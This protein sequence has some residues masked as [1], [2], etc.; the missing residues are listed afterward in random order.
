MRMRSHSH[1]QINHEKHCDEGFD[2][3]YQKVGKILFL[4]QIEVQKTSDDYDFRKE[5]NRWISCIFWVRCR[6]K[7]QAGQ[8]QRSGRCIN[9]PKLISSRF[10][11]RQ[12][13]RK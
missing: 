10:G 6:K 5:M 2:D 3:R 9:R 11:K 12:E 1:N 4:M 13:T 8:N 7:A